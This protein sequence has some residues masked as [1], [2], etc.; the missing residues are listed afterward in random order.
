MADGSVLQ[1][2]F[3]GYTS[4]ID[5]LGNQWESW[6]NGEEDY[7]D[8]SGDHTWTSADASEQIMEHYLGEGAFDTYYYQGDGSQGW[9]QDSTIYY[10]DMWYW[11]E[12]SF[13]WCYKFGDTSSL[14][15][16][17]ADGIGCLKT[18]ASNEVCYSMYNDEWLFSDYN[19]QDDYQF[20]YYAHWSWGTATDE[21]YLYDDLHD[22]WVTV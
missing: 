7:Y 13:K 1:W 19:H 21:W 16:V 18:G 15:C 2:D 9:E 4:Y 3:E 20:F 8:V 17:T 12:G 6:P 14:A 5:S 10:G 22:P 11:D